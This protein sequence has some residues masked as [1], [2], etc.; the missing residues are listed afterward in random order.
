MPDEFQA[1]TRSQA[2]TR[3]DIFSHLPL[4]IIQSH[5]ASK[6]ETITAHKNPP[7]EKAQDSERKRTHATPRPHAQNRLLAEEK[8]QRET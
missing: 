6:N 8:I 7:I 4:T 2:K 1:K 3:G 5:P